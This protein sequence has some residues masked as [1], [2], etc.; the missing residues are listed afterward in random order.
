MKLNKYQLVTKIIRTFLIT[1][2][3][4]FIMPLLLSRILNVCIKNNVLYEII[5]YSIIFIVTTMLFKDEYYNTFKPHF[6]NLKK[7][8]I[9][10]ISIY[11]YGLIGMI[12]SNVLINLLLSNQ[13][14]YNESI[15]REILMKSPILFIFN[16]VLVGPIC[17]EL[18]FRSN[19]KYIKNDKLYIIITASIFSLLHTINGITNPIMLI[20]FIPYLSLGLSFAYI[21]RKTNNIHSSIFF[22]MLHNGLTVLLLLI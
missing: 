8:I 14:P 6:K 5:F 19:Y 16:A 20:Y 9:S 10:N 18:V 17:E 13:M 7:N 12:G 11:A 2:L 15:N 3:Y 1:I 22:H 21:Y 4:L